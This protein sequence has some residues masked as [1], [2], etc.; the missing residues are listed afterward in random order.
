M[1][2][3]SLIDINRLIK[4]KVIWRSGKMQAIVNIQ[5]LIV[6][7][8]ESYGLF[9]E[10]GNSAEW[11][12]RFTVAGQSASQRYDG[13]R[14]GNVLPVNRQFIV[15][16]SNI[17][18]LHVEVSGYEIDD[19]SANDP[20]PLATLIIT[21]ATNWREGQTFKF[22]AA[23]HEDFSYEVVLDIRSAEQT[24]T[25]TSAITEAAWQQFELAAS[26][27]ASVNGG[28]AAVSRIPNSMMVDWKGRLSAGCLLV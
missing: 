16:L 4:S 15:E 2:N 12:L 27:S 7:K 1:E 20:L 23:G 28:I 24:G 18:S 9:S 14:D 11:D 21:P 8:S 13:T 10:P 17:E 3:F 25:S 26:G 6:H 22:S 19:S 5:S